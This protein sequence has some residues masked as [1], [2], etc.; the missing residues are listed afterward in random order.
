M[1]LL[2]SICSYTEG[3]GSRTTG[4]L[5]A[6][7][8]SIQARTRRILRSGT[9][10][11]CAEHEHGLVVVFSRF[12]SCWLCG[13]LSCFACCLSLFFAVA[14]FAPVQMVAAVRAY[15][16]RLVFAHVITSIVGAARSFSTSCCMSRFRYFL[17]TR[18][19]LACLYKCHHF[20]W[21]F[22]L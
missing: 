16:V 11:L 12:L 20:G 3:S 22:A 1:C 15:S 19:F 5:I 13:A 21:S 6:C 7:L 10:V 17:R 8:R 9:R 2:L 14:A 4:G 18:Y